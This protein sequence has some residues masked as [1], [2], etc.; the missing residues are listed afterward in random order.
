MIFIRILAVLLAL[1]SSV[2]A[3]NVVMLGG[4]EASTLTDPC[5]CPTSVYKFCY[6]GDYSG[7]VDK[8]CFSNGSVVKDASLNSVDVINSSYV[9]YNAANEV[10]RWA[11][12]NKDGIDDTIGTLFFTYKTPSLIAGDNILIEIYV[13]TNNYISIT[14]VEYLGYIRVYHK[15]NGNS[16]YLTGGSFST[17]SSYRI[18]Y[19]WKTGNPGG[20]KL[21]IVPLGS[22]TSW[23][24]ENDSNLLTAFSVAI[25]KIQFG[26]TS[27]GSVYDTNRVSDLIIL[28]DYSA[29]DPL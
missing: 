4:G 28:G 26:K 23:S 29:N 5:S 24:A 2:W 1:C 27:L 13:N 22:A 9:E 21:S 11:V 20:H 14:Y 3:G 12:S 15:G 10:I 25:D 16:Q 17:S 8:A 18:G 19:T 7:D 6:T